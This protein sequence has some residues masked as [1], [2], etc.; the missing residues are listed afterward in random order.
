VIREGGRK[1]WREG[2][3]DRERRDVGQERERER[4]RRAID[5]VGLA[6][7]DDQPYQSHLLLPV[8]ARH[9]TQR[10]QQVYFNKKLTSM[11]PRPTT[12]TSL[13]LPATHTANTK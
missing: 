2:G 7:L 11:N 12:S 6:P 4:E 3:R 10:E 5:R 1:I 8:Y 13:L 9:S